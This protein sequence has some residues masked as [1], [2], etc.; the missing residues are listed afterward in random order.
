M[1][2]HRE[3][4]PL[5]G[6][7]GLSQGCQTFHRVLHN[8]QKV[9]IKTSQ[10]YS[11]KYKLLINCYILDFSTKQRKKLPLQPHKILLAS[12]HCSRVP[13]FSDSLLHVSQVTCHVS[14]AKCHMLFVT[15][16]K[17]H[18]FIFLQSC[19]A[20]RLRVCYQRGQ[21]SFYVIPFNGFGE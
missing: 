18:Y 5:T 10:K 20:S 6:R 3:A 14:C 19:V 1:A 11:N 7:P 9:I 2:S 15:Y 16:H 12:E 4:G 13:A 17:S 21:A 8:L